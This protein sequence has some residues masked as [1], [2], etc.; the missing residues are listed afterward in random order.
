MPQISVIVPVY[1]GVRFLDSALGSLRGQT[2]SDWECIAVDDGS[3]DGSSC[4]LEAHAAADPRI[5]VI[6]QANAGTSVA[7][8]A[9]MELADGRY[10]AFLDEDDLYHPRFLETLHA[11]ARST[12]ADV[13]GCE[14]V[15]FGEDEEPTWAGDCPSEPTWT[16]AD[17]A[18]IAELASRY[19]DGVPFEIWRNLYRRDVVTRHLF[20]AGVRVEQDLHW[21]YTLLPRLDRYVR[22]PWPGYA[23]RINRSSGGFLHP[24]AASLISLTATDQTVVSQV[25]DELHMTPDQRRRLAKAMSLMLRWCIWPPLRDGVRLDA[26]QS[27]RLRRGLRTLQA[28]GVD[29]GAALG[30]GSRIRYRLFQMTGAT[31]WIRRH[32]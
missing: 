6:H 24:D 8:N 10:I 13:V 18:G 7:R 31:G 14:F 29:L 22:L 26:D 12:G 1:K 21:M 32:R 23:W 19:Y 9:A 11:A 5:R 20:P 3:T 28:H 25:P 27:R 30:L 16:I 2:F 17:R 4:V 15:K